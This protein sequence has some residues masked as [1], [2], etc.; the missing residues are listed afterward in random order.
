MIEAGESLT[1]MDEY[2]EAETEFWKEQD[3]WFDE[4]FG[5]S[6]RTRVLELLVPKLRKVSLAEGLTADDFGDR[7][8]DAEQVVDNIAYALCAFWTQEGLRSGLGSPHQSGRIWYK[9]D[10]SCLN[11]RPDD[12]EGA[13]P[14]DNGSLAWTTTW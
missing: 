13:S 12:W 10:L 11:S 4:K 9:P 6:Q 5:T 7:L 8:R 14:V 3:R 1:E 2:L